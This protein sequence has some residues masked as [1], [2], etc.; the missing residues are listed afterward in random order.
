M[1]THLH[2]LASLEAAIEESRE[3]PVLLFKHSR[4]CGISCE[5]YD[6]LRSHLDT[7][8]PGAVYKV[9]TVQS[10]RQ[11]SDEAAA[12]LG[13]RHETP[14]AILL[15]DG[16]PVWKASHFRITAAALADALAS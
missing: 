6:E 8:P 4:T 15:R 10:H 3:R 11:V 5:A 13:V 16:Q 7:V 9:I 2:D 14:Q 1:L 12:R